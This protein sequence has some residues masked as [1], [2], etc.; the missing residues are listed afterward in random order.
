M[1]IIITGSN[2]TIG[3]PL[4]E[5]LKQKGHNVSKIDLLH[6]HDNPYVRADI[7]NHRELERAFKQLNADKETIVY[8]LAAEFGRHNGEDYYEKVWNTNAVGVHNMLA[9]Q[10]EIGFKMIFASSSE[11][12]GE[13]PFD[14]EFMDEDMTKRIPLRHHNDYA[15][16]K[17]I[18][19]QQIQNAIRNWGTQTMIMRLFNAY[20]PGEYYH[21]Y[22]SVICLFI[23]RALKGLPYT[24]YDGYHRV[25][26]YI[27]DFIETFSNAAE[28]F[29]PGEII[30]IG[31]SEYRPIMDVHT[32]ISDILELPYDRP[33]VSISKQDGFNTVNKRP[34]ITKAQK[35]LGHNPTTTLEEGLQ[36]TVEW[37]KKEYNFVQDRIDIN[38]KQLNITRP[39]GYSNDNNPKF[40]D[41]RYR[42]IR[43]GR[44]IRSTLFY[45]NLI[46]WIPDEKISLLDIGCGTGYG[47]KYIQDQKPNA[48]LSGCDYSGYA[49]QKA[50]EQYPDIAFFEHDISKDKLTQNYDYI[51]LIQTLEHLDDPIIVIEK[52]LKHCKCLIISVP[53]K[54]ENENRYHVYQNFTKESFQSFDIMDYQVFFKRKL[55]ANEDVD[56]KGYASGKGYDLYVKLRGTI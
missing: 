27:D 36:K 26:Q 41:R 12:Y 42:K 24:V 20:G 28:N 13:G 52:L 4:C 40:Y 3:R 22:R 56:G 18:N 16:S 45:K 1:N 47:L 17:W 29:I 43:K 51:L 38:K 19:E 21:P 55:K 53:Y 11:I 6:S 30:N 7:A 25:F 48:E 33:E 32:I 49:I 5:R 44:E 39:F 46:E 15:M 8:H 14:K 34:D 23:Y 9:I 2:G 31:G 54:E 50:T 37:M 10:K 35:L